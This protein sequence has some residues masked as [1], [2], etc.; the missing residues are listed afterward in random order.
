MPST[1]GSKKGGQDLGNLQK[2]FLLEYV[3]DTLDDKLSLKTNLHC[4]KT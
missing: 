4:L 2:T 3:D 1:L